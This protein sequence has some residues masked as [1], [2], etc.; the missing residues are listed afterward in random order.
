MKHLILIIFVLFVSCHAPKN[1]IQHSQIDQ[2]TNF[3]QHTVKQNAIADTKSN[4]T[5]AAKS[6]KD[7]T[8]GSIERVTKT[9][10]YDTDKP[11]DPNTG[12][13]PIKS[14]SVTTEKN[15]GNRD[16]QTD[17]GVTINKED[18]HK[19]NSKTQVTTG[20]Q[21]NTSKQI[22]TAEKTKPP[23]VKY[24]MWI[25]VICSVVG[26]LIYLKWSKIKALFGFF[27]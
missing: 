13:P 10:V 26:I 19:D 14:E 4:Q 22:K 27:S 20:A 23:A 7:H 12:K 25:L 21:V 6:V 24:W 15:T 5:D 2:Q 8:E 1:V 16:V 11:S 17:I 9:T 18:T 3:D